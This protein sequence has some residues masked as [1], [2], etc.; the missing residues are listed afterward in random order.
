MLAIYH[1][2]RREKNQALAS[3]D[4]VLELDPDDIEALKLRDRIQSMTTA[5]I[6]AYKTSDIAA[7][8]YY[9]GAR[10]FNIVRF[11]LAIIFFPMRIMA[12]LFFG[13]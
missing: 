5:E 11:I 2:D 3:I 8:T 10:T 1:W 4:R 9:A 13:K 7:A 12:R 6:A